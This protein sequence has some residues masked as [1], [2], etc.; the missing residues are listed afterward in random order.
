MPKEIKIEESSGN[1]FKDLG[2]SDEEAEE[3]LLKAKLGVEILRILEEHELTPADAAKVLGTRQREVSRLL[4]GKFSYYTIE[5]LMRF[6]TRLNRNIEI[7][8]TPSAGRVGH[9]QVVAV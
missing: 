5:R 4:Q 2:F 9:Q 6:L 1:V 7:R 8:I 3:E